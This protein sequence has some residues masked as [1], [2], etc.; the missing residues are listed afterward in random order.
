[1]YSYEPYGTYDGVLAVAM[2]VP[3]DRNRTQAHK[4]KLIF[5]F[6]IYTSNLTNYGITPFVYFRPE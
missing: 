2:K 3:A 4:N 5:I 6:F 1:M